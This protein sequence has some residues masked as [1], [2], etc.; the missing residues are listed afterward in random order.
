MKM[1]GNLTP[2]VCFPD[3]EDDRQ[4]VVTVIYALDRIAGSVAHIVRKFEPLS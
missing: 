1:A 4:C 2:L 3:V